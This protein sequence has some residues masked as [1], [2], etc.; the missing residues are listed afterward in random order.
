MKG[1]RRCPR[2]HRDV[3]HPDKGA[4]ATSRRNGREICSVC[5]KEEAFVDA[6][7][8]LS[9]KQLVREAHWRRLAGAGGRG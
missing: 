1:Y 8:A 3:M 9:K 4:N 2:C 6:G 7:L 5:G